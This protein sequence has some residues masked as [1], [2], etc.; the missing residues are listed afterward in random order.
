MTI[1]KDDEAL[2]EAHRQK[3][4]ELRAKQAAAVKER[5]E[6]RGITLVHTGDGKGKSTAAFGLTLRAAGAGFKVLVVQ[7]TKGKWKTGEGKL[8]GTLPGVDHVIVGD[9]FTWNTQ[10]RR[11]DIEAAEAGWKVCVEAIEA[12]R[13]DDPRYNL[14]IMDEL[15]IILRYDYL[16]VAKVV[17]AVKNKP[18]DLHLCITGRDAK[19]ELIEVA[20]TVTEFMKV[21]HAYDAGIKAMRGIEF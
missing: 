10:D 20:D 11:A 1:D 12:S 18:E 19:P 7:F 13:G 9:G 5:T 4:K 6:Q 14:I 15:N 8:L 17:E 2:N 16:D 3:M 21:K